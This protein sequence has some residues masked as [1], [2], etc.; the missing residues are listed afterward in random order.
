M[1]RA[2]SDGECQG[3]IAGQADGTLSGNRYL[4]EDLAG[5]DGVDYE[6]TAQGWTLPPFSQLSTFPQ[7]FSPFPT[8]LR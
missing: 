7:I 8:G 3:A 4:L 5:L 1:V 6:G 2:D